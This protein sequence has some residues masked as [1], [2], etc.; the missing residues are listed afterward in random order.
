MV[1]T[2][3]NGVTLCLNKEEHFA[4]I[5]HESRFQRKRRLIPVHQKVRAMIMIAYC[6]ISSIMNREDM[7]TEINST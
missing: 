6:L 1:M 2:T 5:R 3:M 4:I 7:S